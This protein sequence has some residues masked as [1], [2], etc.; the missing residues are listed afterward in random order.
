MT[1]ISFHK[2][3]DIEGQ[4]FSLIAKAENG[5]HY[6]IERN[7][8]D[9]RVTERELPSFN[10]TDYTGIVTEINQE[11]FE[12]ILENQWGYSKEAPVP[13]PTETPATPAV[14]DPNVPTPAD[15]TPTPAAASEGAETQQGAASTESTGDASV[16]VGNASSGNP[17]TEG[18]DA[19][20]E[21]A[22]P[23]SETGVVE[24]AKAE[25][26]DASPKE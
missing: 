6:I 17:A 10:V 19:S 21:S 13:T 23:S 11:E 8:A 5:A 16:E 20:T 1:N 22:S 24:P 12:D 2:A 3:T 7:A 26:V 25:E 14:S 18:S 4:V 15:S 9:G